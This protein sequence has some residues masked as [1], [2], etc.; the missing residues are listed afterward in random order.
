MVKI[1]LLDGYVDEPTCLGVPPYISPYPRYTAGAIWSFDKKAEINYVTIDQIRTGEKHLNLLNNSDVIITIAGVSVPGRYLSG[2]PASPNELLS[3]LKNISHPLKILCGPAAR[4]GFGG[5]GGKKTKDISYAKD[6]FDLVIKGDTEIVINELLENKLNIEKIDA[7]RC[8][9]Q[10]SDIRDYSIK[11][12]K[13]VLQHTFYPHYL[14]TEIETYRG[15]PRGI[16]GGC[17]FCSEPQKGPPDFR[18]IKDVVDEIQ[19]LYD[20]GIRHFRLGNQPCIFSYMAENADSEEFP[21][22]NP[23]ALKKLFQ[24]IRNVAP[25]LKT[26]HIDNANPG[27]VARYPD[28]SRRIAKT[29][30]KYHTSGDVAAFGVE[31]VDP[32]VIKKNNLKATPEEVY[33]AIKLL[34]QVGSKKGSNGMPELLPGL[35]FVFGLDGE[36]KNTYQLDYEFLE[37]ILDDDLLLRRINLRQIIP[38]PGTKMYNVGNRIITKN[39]QHFKRFKKRVRENIEQPLLKKTLPVESV[40]KNIYAE[41]YDGKLTLGRQIGSYPLLIGLPGVLPLHVFYDVK[42]VDYG[43]RSITAVP[44]PL[45]INHA[46]RETIQA[47]P[48]LAAKRTNRILA[49]RPFRNSEDF[50]K[51]L[52]ESE[53]AE[54]TLSFIVFK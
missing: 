31:S 16:A 2:F 37:K 51:A 54:K 26:L 19:A 39:K 20:T 9:K 41:K 1:T 28:E 8:R 17:S 34:N 14:I 44:Y 52:D 43:Y 36:T 30:I 40:V 49:N 18:P 13:I 45:D 15:C 11:G 48:G 3:I 38:I 29:I 10:A 46:K 6:V 32:V 4:H 5:S 53:I 7:T 24:E 47:I 27:V 22:P 50:I 25:G 21:R 42:V 12:S 23:E 35:N 33:S